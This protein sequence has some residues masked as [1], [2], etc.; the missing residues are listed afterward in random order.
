[1]S[2]ND[3]NLSVKATEGE[4]L[5]IAPGTDDATGQPVLVMTIRPDVNKGFKTINLMIAPENGVIAA[6]KIQIALRHPLV[7][8]KFKMPQSISS[9]EAYDEYKKNH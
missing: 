9:L 6:E 5:A 8:G 3:R 2:G 4:I 7:K 1:M